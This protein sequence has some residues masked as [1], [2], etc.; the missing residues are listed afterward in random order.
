[1]K[2]LIE[3]LEK[4]KKEAPI[5]TV[6]REVITDA[7]RAIKAYETFIREVEAKMAHA[8]NSADEGLEKT[9]N[10]IRHLREMD[11]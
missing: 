8:A 7:I 3:R 5:I 2:K 1:M 11:K 9:Q 6:E 4:V 10:M